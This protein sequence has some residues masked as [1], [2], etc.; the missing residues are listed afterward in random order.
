VK[1]L[2]LV[3]EVLVECGDDGPY[4]DGAVGLLL[5]GRRDE[6]DPHASAQLLGSADRHANAA[7]AKEVADDLA[8]GKVEIDEIL[9]LRCGH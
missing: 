2:A 3:G 7:G 4:V 8:E 6:A 9:G 1:P 5:H